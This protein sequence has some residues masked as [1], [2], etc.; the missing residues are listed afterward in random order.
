[1][2]LH[3]GDERPIDCKLLWLRDGRIGLEF[4]HEIELARAEDAMAARLRN[5]IA[6]YFPDATFEAPV[7]P[8]PEPDQEIEAENRAEQRHAL[9][10]RG[11]LHYDY[12]STPARLHDVSSDGVMLE[13]ES[14][15]APGAEPLIDFGEA[16]SVFGTVVWAEAG[17]AGLR[18][19]QPFDWTQLLKA[20]AAPETPH[21]EAPAYLR[22]NSHCDS[23]WEENWKNMSANELRDLDGFLKR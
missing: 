1:V 6:G 9:I 18:F 14:A 5:V 23:R 4:A 12:Q 13:T 15:L 10:R 11:T 8:Q 22:N 19:N 7:E 16:G 2:K 21:W 17:R 3:L 20:P